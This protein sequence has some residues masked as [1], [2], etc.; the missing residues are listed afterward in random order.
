MPYGYG[1]WEDGHQYALQQLGR[2]LTR[3]R[4]SAEANADPTAAAA[5]LYVLKEIA[6]THGFATETST[7]VT[8]KYK[9]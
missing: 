3:L 9:H 5:M 4:A 7:V 6:V 2:T 8:Y 1:E